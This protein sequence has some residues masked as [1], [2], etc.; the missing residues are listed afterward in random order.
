MPQR[1]RVLVRRAIASE[2]EALEAL[3]RRASLENRGDRDALLANPDAIELPAAN[4][5]G[6]GVSSPRSPAS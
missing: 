1:P 5:E 2:R 4:I 6:G 3:Q